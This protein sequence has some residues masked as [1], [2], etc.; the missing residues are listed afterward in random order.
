MTFS[1][2]NTRQLSSADGQFF[3]PMQ[4]IAEW[5][6]IGLGSQLALDQQCGARIFLSAARAI[7]YGHVGY[8]H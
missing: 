8:G 5:F 3:G 4:S 2:L 1:A 7:G 6:V